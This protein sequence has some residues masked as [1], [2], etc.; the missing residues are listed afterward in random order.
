[1]KQYF[2]EI[3]TPQLFAV[4]NEIK[5]NVTGA[6]S[7]IYTYVVDTSQSIET[8]ISLMDPYVNY[9]FS[10]G[11]T[12][13]TF[14][15]DVVI[16]A[17]ND[18]KIA[19]HGAVEIMNGDAAIHGTIHDA[20]SKTLLIQKSIDAIV[21]LLDAIEIYSL[22][23][24]VISA[25]AGSQGLS[26]A[27]ISGKM[28]LLSKQGNEL[29]SLFTQKMKL[30]KDSLDNFTEMSERIELMHETNLTK[31]Q[32]LGNAMFKGLTEEFARLSGEVL[33]EYGM[34]RTVSETIKKI[35]EKFQYEDLMRQDMEKAM[36]A[37]EYINEHENFEK[38]IPLLGETPDDVSD[39]FYMLAVTKFNDVKTDSFRLENELSESLSDVQSVIDC[40]KKMISESGTRNEHLTSSGDMLSELFEKL[41]SLKGDFEEYINTVLKYKNNIHQDLVQIDA[42]MHSFRDFF[43][44]IVSIAQQFQTIILLTRINIARDEHLQQL[45]GGTLSDVSA[46]PAEINRTISALLPLYNEVSQSLSISVA[47]Y[48]ERLS[49]QKTILADCVSSMQ[50]VSVQIHESKKYHDDFLSESTRC[51][52]Q[53]VSFLKSESEKF[54]VFSSERDHIDSVIQN[55]E[56]IM[57]SQSEFFSKNQDVLSNMSTYFD[58][59]SRNGDY[60]SMMLA[61]LAAEYISSAGEKKYGNN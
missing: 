59:E 29:S 24:M 5:N 26:L 43:S 25:K 27:T 42:E 10:G 8:F 7:E 55:A 21:E 19:V 56:S 36:Y 48:D 60:R 12:A 49:K 18:L 23:T 57:D 52:S 50:K 34:I 15:G 13:D 14:L 33:G 61:S 45:L 16:P 53:V 47:Q 9:F 30:L 54:T 3:N 40:F 44:S 38:I 46:I 35:T 6:C 32:L 37:I 1:M 28:A 31:M 58:K 51:T 41:E 11:K 4:L 22:N 2:C 39:I 20:V 17:E